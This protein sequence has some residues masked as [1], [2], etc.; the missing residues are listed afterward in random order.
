MAITNLK[1]EYIAQKRIT[2]EGLKGKPIVNIGEP[3]PAGVSAATIEELLEQGDIAV[4]Q[5]EA[6]DES[7]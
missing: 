4:K 3:L 6:T 5:E 7:A 2:F 1:K